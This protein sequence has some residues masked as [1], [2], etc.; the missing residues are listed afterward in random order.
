VVVNG[1]STFVKRVERELL[2]YP[3]SLEWWKEL[4][5]NLAWN[6][7]PAFMVKSNSFFYIKLKF[8]D[9]NYS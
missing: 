4:H 2:P 6:E 5:A 9:A 7:V 1:D 8:K 3:T